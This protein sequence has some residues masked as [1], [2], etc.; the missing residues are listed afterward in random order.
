MT[1]A[2]ETS[3]PSLPYQNQPH[4]PTVKHIGLIH[5][6]PQREDGRIYYELETSDFDD[7]P[8]YTALS[9]I[10]GPPSPTHNVYVDNH[11]LGV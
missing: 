9:Y 6:E 1:I 4:Q 10:W 3:S 7:A 5:L 11:T 8:E 2:T